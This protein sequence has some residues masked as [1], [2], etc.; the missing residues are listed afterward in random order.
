MYIAGYTA[1]RDPRLQ[2]IR[3]AKTTKTG[4]FRENVARRFMGP[5]DTTGYI[6]WL[7][8]SSKLAVVRDIKLDERS[9]NSIEQTSVEVTVVPS[10]NSPGPAG[11]ISGLLEGVNVVGNCW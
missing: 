8:K 2:N 5:A 6:V 1:P 11:D 7:I 4:S 10:V 3:Y 9:G